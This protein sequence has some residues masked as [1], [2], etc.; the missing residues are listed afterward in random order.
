MNTKA[1]QYV[2]R[3][4]TLKAQYGAD[5]T[6]A[7]FHAFYQAWLTMHQ[8]LGARRIAQKHGPQPIYAFSDCSG[9]ME[10]GALSDI[11]NNA[12]DKVSYQ[13]LSPFEI[14]RLIWT[15]RE[16]PGAIFEGQREVTDAL[17]WALR[18]L[19]YHQFTEAARAPERTVLAPWMEA[20]TIHGCARNLL[21]C[22]AT[23][24]ARNH[25]EVE[26]DAA[27]QARYD[28]LSDE[29]KAAWALAR[30]ETNPP[31][32]TRLWASRSAPA[33]QAD[34]EKHNQE[35]SQRQLKDGRWIEVHFHL[36]FVQ[37]HHADLDGDWS[38]E[39]LYLVHPR[40]GYGTS[41]NI[42]LGDL[43]RGTRA[44]RDGAKSPWHHDHRDW[45]AGRGK[46]IDPLG[47]GDYG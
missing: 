28:A 5:K 41:Y 9:V 46:P 21:Q 37:V 2:E 24:D 3:F 17:L 20:F 33:L 26:T 47:D 19:A 43:A 15:H 7:T 22:S 44:E 12:R 25:Q 16:I 30:R 36:A 11:R 32:L 27:W 14:E 38:D 42:M 23:V 39:R 34:I 40:L 4:N 29:D 8:E 35:V 6:P 18:P 31:G 1:Q 13:A 45:F 10:Q